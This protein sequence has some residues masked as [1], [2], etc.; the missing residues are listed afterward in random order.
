[1]IWLPVVGNYAD[2]D[3]YASIIAYTDLLN[4]RGKLAK[5]YIPFR[6]NYSVP[7]SLRMPEWENNKWDFSDTDEA[8]ILD[9]SIPEVIHKFVPDEQI[10]E[11]IDH[12]AGH[13]KYWEQRLGDR[14]IIE[15]IGA[16]A[17][18]VF[19]WWGECWDYEKMSP[20]IAKLL[21]AAILD[22]TL[23][24][25]AGITTERDRIAAKKLAEIADTTLEEFTGWYFTA[26]S[27]GVIGNLEGAL[28]NDCKVGKG[29]RD[30][31]DFSFGQLIVWDKEKLIEREQKIIEIMDKINLRWAVSILCLSEHKNYILVSSPKVKEYFTSVLECKDV[32]NWL[33]SDK[34]YLRKEIMAR[35]Q[36]R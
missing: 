19:E 36:E 24:F 26:V 29:F 33:V 4:Q 11:L 32:G 35:M 12:H 27:D 10:L 17:T 31:L 2:V 14:A 25:N 28:W 23:D 20:E 1:M 7:E 6:P 15:K 3:L 13:E 22:N 16:V 9:I 30:G 34:L 8:I 18:S 21:L 5:T